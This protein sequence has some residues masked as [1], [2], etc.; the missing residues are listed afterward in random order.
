M[1]HRNTAAADIYLAAAASWRGGGSVKWREKWQHHGVKRNGAI[2][3]AMKISKISKRMK[4]A[5]KRKRKYGVM[6]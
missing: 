3:M 2:S 5:K 1:R 4:M 6:K